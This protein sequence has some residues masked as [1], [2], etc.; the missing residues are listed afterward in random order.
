VAETNKTDPEPVDTAEIAS[1]ET[2]A[3][4][5]PEP[6]AQQRPTPRILPMIVAGALTAGLGFGAAYLLAA[7]YPQMLG[8]GGTAGIQQRLSDHDKRIADLAATVGKLSGKDGGADVGALQADLVASRAA[9]ADLLKKQ[10]ALAAGIAG[11]QEKIAA[12]ESRP[13]ATGAASA[14]EIEAARADAAARIKAASDAAATAQATAAETVRNATI[15]SAMA[16]V[17]SA[18]DSGA[19]F[20]TPLDLLA[21]AGV[22]VPQALLTQEQGVPT[23]AAL[24]QG[25]APAA[26]DALAASLAET[27][28]NGFWDRTMAFLRSET[29]ARSL[30]PRAGNDP[31]AILSRAEAALATGDLRTALTE[32]ASLPDA[33]QARMSE[34]IG[35]AKRRQAATDALANLAAAAK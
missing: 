31:D 32:I 33:G 27:A 12:L 10:Q 1:P 17:Q 35:L 20:G 21:G 24:R 28:G 8:I 11:L 4:V 5:E 23:M 34:W 16:Q 19:A 9:T 6:S 29:G 18:V 26:R 3:P 30:T 15:Q 22:S 2:A 7:R 25:F 13:V 14:A